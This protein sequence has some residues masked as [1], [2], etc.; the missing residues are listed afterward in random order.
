MKRVHNS[1]IYFLQCAVHPQDE[2]RA[3]S[4]RLVWDLLFKWYLKS[5]NGLVSRN[6][7][8]PL[9]SL[10]FRL[11]WKA[12]YVVSFLFSDNASS[13]FF[14]S[15][16][17]VANKLY[18]LSYLSE[19]IEKFATNMLMSAV[20]QSPSGIEHSQSESTGQRVE[21]MV[22]CFHLLLCLLSCF[23]A[24]ASKGSDIF[25]NHWIAWSCPDFTC[26]LMVALIIFII[27][28]DSHTKC[29]SFKL[30]FCTWWY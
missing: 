29:L 4:I 16:Q 14:V 3:K 30:P 24:L 20:E 26:Y 8:G 19:M 15:V 28:G 13:H 2:I 10:N 9:F 18:K 25:M 11:T 5:S 7:L 27:P 17:Q 1:N 6:W 12:R 21:G 22:C 23:M